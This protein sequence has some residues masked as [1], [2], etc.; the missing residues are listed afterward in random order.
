MD[1]PKNSSLIDEVDEAQRETQNKIAEIR[2]RIE[3]KRAE[4]QQQQVRKKFSF[5]AVSSFVFKFFF[6]DFMFPYF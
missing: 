6:F 4:V 1:Q 3:A 2:A 5:Y